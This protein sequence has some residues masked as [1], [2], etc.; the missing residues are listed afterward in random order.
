MNPNPKRT[1]TVSE[2]EASVRPER[3]RQ[4]LKATFFGG[5]CW[6]K[7]DG[8]GSLSKRD[9]EAFIHFQEY[10]EARGK[11][12]GK[13]QPGKREERS[14]LLSGQGERTGEERRALLKSQLPVKEKSTIVECTIFSKKYIAT[15]G[16]FFNNGRKVLSVH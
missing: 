5:D 11:S 1:V 10:T 12:G 4:L 13:W 14:L 8:G 9:F 2:Y 16:G 7:R 3:D 15:V 6:T